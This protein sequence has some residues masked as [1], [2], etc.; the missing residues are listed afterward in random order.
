MSTP[1]APNTMSRPA[2]VPDKDDLA[3]YYMPDNDACSVAFD[4]V[5]V[6]LNEALG[7]LTSMKW[8]DST[9]SG[10]KVFRQSPLI[11]CWHNL[12]L[13]LLSACLPCFSSVTNCRAMSRITGRTCEA[14]ACICLVLN[15]VP[16]YP[17][18]KAKVHAQLR[19]KYGLAGAPLTDCLA[20]CCLSPCLVCQ[21]AVEMQAEGEFAVPYCSEQ[22][23]AA[24]MA[25]AKK[26]AD[27]TATMAK[28]QAERGAK[29]ELREAA[30]EH[31]QADDTPAP[32]ASTDGAL[33]MPAA[34]TS[35][36][37]VGTAPHQ[38]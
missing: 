33:A 36:Q 17:C 7:L 20:S 9:V 1:V 19:T 13:C 8:T 2:D 11:A 32:A 10:D 31:G 35:P 22:Q 37:E 12:P 38:A 29:T 6:A 3:A 25:S 4:S 27:K 24:A 16:L 18:Y 34:P 23:A 14:E 26:V 28:S 21:E 5:P 30:K 15:C